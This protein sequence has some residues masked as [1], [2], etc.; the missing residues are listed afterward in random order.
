MDPIINVQ[1][2]TVWAKTGT[3][4]ARKTTRD[5]DCDGEPDV[6]LDDP[7]HAWFVGLVGQGD[8]ETARPRYAIAII[9]EYG[10]SGGRTAGPVAN[11]IMRALRSE[12]YLGQGP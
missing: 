5:I 7:S 3:A 8:A 6:S 10:G 12:G 11:E 1:D 4:Q 2:V 9:V